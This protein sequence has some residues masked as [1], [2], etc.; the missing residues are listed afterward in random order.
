[1][2][3]YTPAEVSGEVAELY[4]PHHRD[5]VAAYQ[6]IILP[7]VSSDQAASVNGS[8]RIIR[9][10]S[11]VQAAEINGIVYITAYRP[12]TVAITGAR[13]FDISDP[14]IYM[15]TPSGDGFAVLSAIPGL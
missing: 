12:D 1:M 2:G 9:N 15:L 11:S 13:Q 5:S 10:D 7:D 6:Y 14:G 8:V 3:S 4:I